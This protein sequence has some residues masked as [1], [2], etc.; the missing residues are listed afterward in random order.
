[1][2]TVGINAH[3]ADSAICIFE[4]KKLLFALEEERLNRIKH[5]AGLPCESIIYGL[6]YCNIEAK[7]IDNITF[8]TNPLSNIFPKTKY[9]FQNYLL[10]AKSKEIF[11]RLNTKIENKKTLKKN[12]DLNKNIKFYFVDHHLSHLSSAFYPSKF[13]RSLGLSID[14]FGDFCSIAIAKCYKNK[15]KIIDKIFFPNSLGVVYEALTQLIGFKKYGEEYKLMGLSSYGKP[16]FFDKL[17]NNLFHK[18]S[19]LETNLK[20]FN[21]HN[22]NFKYTFSGQP[23]Q[24]NLYNEKI[25]NVL[26]LTENDLLN[27]EVKRDI[28]ASTQKLFEYYFIKILNRLKKINFSNNIIFAGGCALNSLANKKIFDDKYFKN[29]FIP[30]AP[31]DAGGSIGSAL[32][33][34]SKKKGEF[35]NLQS[36]YLG[37]EFTNE[38][39][40]QI[41][42]KNKIFNKFKVTFEN[43]NEDLYNII[44]EKL[45]K[46]QVIGLFKGRMEFGA[47]ALGNRSI[48]ASPCEPDMK[49]II[50]KKIK[51]RENFRPFAPAVLLEDKLEWFEESH[52][53]SYMSNVENI[54]ENKKIKIPAV[55]HIDGTGRVQT[56]SKENNIHFYEIIKKF[57]IKTN[58]PIL[59]NTS[60]NENEPI[61]LDPYNA[62]QCFERTE[63]DTLILENFIISRQ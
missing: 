2:I 3:H 24:N 58:V 21:Y 49:N 55:T 29:I 4:G 37:P 60:F 40:K 51:K 50:N 56:V 5:W 27:E 47:R 17:A 30:Y 6:K 20:Y 46:K 44:V 57:K 15:I 63:I 22:R 23:N 34:L 14:G 10:S 45:L 11:N 36:P 25:L 43:Y 41:L 18:N 31:G 53:N 61:V 62:L 35:Q 48:I 38:Q 12:L 54:L 32:H 13:D 16:I 59:L 7:D 19:F 52:E 28:A 42:D 8:N 39:I 33:V 26:N 1:M 9:F